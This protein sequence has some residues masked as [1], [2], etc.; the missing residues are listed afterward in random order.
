M[1]RRSKLAS[2]VVVLAALTLLPG[3]EFFE[4]LG[5][6]DEVPLTI[7]VVNELDAGLNYSVVVSG[8]FSDTFT[9]ASGSRGTMRGN[10]RDGGLFRVS[11]IALS[12]PEGNFSGICTFTRSTMRALSIVLEFDSDDFPR[13]RCYGF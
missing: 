2:T 6:Y 1:M 5:P 8:P 4:Q 10:V 9:L 3:C 11:A 7:T 12:G 13:V